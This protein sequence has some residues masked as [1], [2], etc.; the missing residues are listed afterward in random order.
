LSL[1]GSGGCIGLEGATFSDDNIGG[2]IDIL[3]YV[4]WATISLGYFV[5]DGM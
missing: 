4:Y 5:I 1:A 3:G 2:L